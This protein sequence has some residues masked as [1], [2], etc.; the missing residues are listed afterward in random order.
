MSPSEKKHLYLPER[1]RSFWKGDADLNLPLVYLAWGYRDFHKKPIPASCHE[2]WVCALIEEGCPTMMVKKQSMMMPA[3]TLALIGPDCPFG[4]KDSATGPSKF[5]LWMWRTFTAP[6]LCAG[7]NATFVTRLLN[8]RDRKPFVL[9]HD[10]CRREVLR[11]AAPDKSYLEGCRIIFEATMQRTIKSQLP[12]SQQVSELGELAKAWMNRHF[13][14][15]EP[16]ARLC[17]YLSI[18]QSTLYRLFMAEFR[19]SPLSCFHQLRMQKA[20]ELLTTSKLPVKEIAF[21]LGYKHF[22]DFSRAYRKHYGHSP[23]NSR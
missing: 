1:D 9:L 14:S 7:L 11:P 21:Q 10:L 12:N 5:L 16:V 18:S 15:E 6:D 13:E 4:W 17:D 22:N 20:S 19:M 23:T 8:R 2:G 3:G